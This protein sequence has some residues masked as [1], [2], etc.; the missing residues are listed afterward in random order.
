[1]EEIFYCLEAKFEDTREVT[2]NRN[3]KKD[4]QRKSKERG[5]KQ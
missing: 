4:R 5:D 2:R 1:M 3:S